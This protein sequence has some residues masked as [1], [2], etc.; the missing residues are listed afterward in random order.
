[1]VGDFIMKEVS[2]KTGILMFFTLFAAYVTF[3]AS[4]VGGSNLGPQIIPT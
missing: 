2:H 1:M 3:A 4:W